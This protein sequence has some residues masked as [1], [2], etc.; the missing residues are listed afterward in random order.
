MLYPPRAVERAMLAREVLLRAMNHE[1]SWTQAAEILGITPRGLRRLRQRMEEFG[2]EGLVDR[3]HGR[4][5]PRRTAVAEVE[6]ILGLYRERY[7]GFNVRHFTSLV[8]REHGVTLSYTCV[9]QLLQG[10]GLVKRCRARGRHRMKRPR[11]PRFGQMLHLDGSTH[12]WLALM[13]GEKQTLIQSVDDATSRVLYAQL[14]P[15]ETAMA[16]MNALAEIV[17][18]YGIP[19]SLYTDR[20]SWAFETP[21]AGG[22]VSKTHLT[23]VGEALK[24]LGV[25]HIASYSPQGRGRS[26]RMNETLQGR[27]INELRAA[28]VR[29]VEAANRYLRERY[30]PA[31]NEEFACEP[32]DP[33]AAFVA[34]GDVKLD[35]IFFEQAERTVAKDNTVSWDALTLQIR[36][37]PSRP[38]CANL[39][40]S[41]RRHLDGSYTIWRGAQRLGNYD[42]QGKVVADI[43]TPAKSAQSG[44][45]RVPASGRLRLPAA[46]TRGR[47]NV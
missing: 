22:K 18:V 33:E 23:Q 6:R 2:Y 35:Q 24:R 17:S 30:L 10:A 15:A 46:G 11:K 43:T 39:R 8:R 20:A 28:G 45:G 14:W 41:V 26:E 36:K 16:V 13:P 12:A 4:P 29:D 40:V 27:L 21:V 3:R 44:A 38:T 5:S 1:Y 34:L 37:Q 19:E 32:A 25:E 31:H 42:A 7:Y 9:K 47:A